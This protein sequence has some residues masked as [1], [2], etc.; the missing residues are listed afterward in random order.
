MFLQLNLAVFQKTGGLKLVSNNCKIHREAIVNGLSTENVNNIITNMAFLSA[1]N[2]RHAMER[3]MTFPLLIKY[4]KSQVKLHVV[5]K[6]T[7]VSTLLL[8]WI[9][10]NI[11]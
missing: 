1:Q 3:N 5:R 9:M 2:Q 6:L 10:Y 8:N 4:E 11:T 7:Y